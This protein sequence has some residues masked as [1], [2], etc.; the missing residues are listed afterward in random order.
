[1]SWMISDYLVGE[2]RKA[3]LA[4]SYRTRRGIETLAREALAMYLATQGADSLECLAYQTGRPTA[5]LF[6]EAMQQYLGRASL[7]G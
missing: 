4:L 7:A 6:D 3:L 1:M 5:L 2:Q